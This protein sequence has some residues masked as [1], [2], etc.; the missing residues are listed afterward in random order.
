MSSSDDEP[1]IGRRK[2]SLAPTGKPTRIVVIDS[3]SDNDSPLP[4]WVRNHTSPFRPAGKATSLHSDSD[5]SDIKEVL[6]PLKVFPSPGKR[7]GE[8]EVRASLA[9]GGLTRSPVGKVARSGEKAEPGGRA[10]TMDLDINVRGETDSLKENN[11]GLSAVPKKKLDAILS[12]ARLGSTSTSAELGNVN[13]RSNLK[14]ENS[15]QAM[16]EGTQPSQT[17]RLGPTGTS[18]PGG[19]PTSC[20]TLP[21]MLPEKLSNVKLLVELE[22]GGGGDGKLTASRGATDL[23]GDSGAIGRFIARPS[24]DKSDSHQICIDLKGVV[25]NA[26]L[27][28]AASTMAL[29]NI[30]PT[31]AKVETLFSDFMQL[32]ED[33]RFSHMID[34]GDGPGA[35]GILGD[36][37][38]EHPEE[39]THGRD[40]KDTKKSKTDAKDRKHGT[41]SRSGRGRAKGGRAGK[42]IAPSRT[43][44]GVKKPRQ[45]G[46]ARKTAHKSSKKAKGRK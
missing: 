11:A 25:Y 29:V 6:S 44:S 5:D 43:Q 37:D 17:S 20:S 35:F 3:S 36:D 34:P 26:T 39:E 18:M 14:A 7:Q 27:V 33:A 41:Q 9:A 32:R 19:I 38:D 45:K 28:P 21:V 8:E 24:T 10:I 23:S 4:S 12:A 22:N 30:G 13:S 42:A 40:E 16:D 31:E 2:G 1:L 15:S 46:T